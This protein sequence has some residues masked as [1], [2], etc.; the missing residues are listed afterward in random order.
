MNLI[1]KKLIL[2]NNDLLNF[3]SITSKIKNNYDIKTYLNNCIKY[4]LFIKKLYIKNLSFSYI[5]N[6]N[7]INKKISNKFNSS[8]VSI[9]RHPFIENRYIL[10]IRC[11]NYKINLFGHSSI[12]S[13]DICLTSNIMIITDDNFNI[14]YRNIY[15]PEISDIPYIGIE[16]IRL[17]NFNKKI[18][19]IG[20]AYDKITNKVRITSSQ[21]NLHENYKLNFITPSFYTNFNWEKN[22]VFFENNN[23]IFVIYKWS[24]IYICKIDY[25]NN[26]LNLIKKIDVPDEFSNFRGSTNGI[27]Y[28]DKIW[29]IIHC[30]VNISNQKNYFHRFVVLNNDLTLYGYSKIFKF[31]NY[32]IEFCIGLELSYRNNFIITYSTL[33]STTKLIVISYDIIKSLIVSFS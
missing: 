4:P 16:D 28:N 29:F 18:F 9:I 15:H 13:N 26:A 14:I 33:D 27:Y 3:L 8:S 10:N 22:W 23:E 1:K 17:F 32:L 20:S 12:H 2:K 30:Q 6:F 21:Y 25:N 7:L 24:P 19:Y 31:E 5:K 11:V